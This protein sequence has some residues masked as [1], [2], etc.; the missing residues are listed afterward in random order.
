MAF[1]LKNLPF[2]ASVKEGE[3]IHDFPERFA[4]HLAKLEGKRV[5]VTVKKFYKT[6]TLPQ[7]RY[8]RGYVLPIVSAFMGYKRFERDRCYAVLKSLYLKTTDNK[9]NEYIKSLA[10]NSDDPVNTQL[11]C[12][13]TEQIRDMVVMEYNYE[14]KD[15]DKSRIEDV[16]S[17]VTEI[18]KWG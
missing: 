13:F 4:I 10:G 6:R 16:E 7:L 11:M 18:E 1:D 17:L 14:I 15:P 12:E 2:V 9:G 5:T 8:L 3:L